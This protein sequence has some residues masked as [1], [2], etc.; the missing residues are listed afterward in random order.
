[1]EHPKRAGDRR[2]EIKWHILQAS[3][4]SW[5]SGVSNSHTKGLKFKELIIIVKKKDHLLSAYFQP[6][7]VLSPLH[8]LSHLILS[9]TLMRSRCY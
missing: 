1:M 5:G 8:I 6:D 9:T 4:I 3:Q 7:P 2:G